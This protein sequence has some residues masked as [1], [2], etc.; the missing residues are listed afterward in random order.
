VAHLSIEK[1][2]F[3]RD[4]RDA[5]ILQG[6]QEGLEAGREAG[7]E[8]GREAGVLQGA[9]RTLTQLLE[10]KFG[11]M[12]KWARTRLSQ[13]TASQLDRWTIKVLAAATLEE[14]IGRR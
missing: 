1:N 8:E 5:A 7:R 13:A 6:R 2:A 9:A 4:I 3:L 12:P 11:P 14:A 10:T